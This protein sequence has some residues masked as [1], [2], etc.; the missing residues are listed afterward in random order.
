[1]TDAPLRETPLAAAHAA[2]GARFT[3]F[4]GWRMPLQYGSVLEEHRAVRASAGLFDLSHMG[5]LWVT[6]PGAGDALAY[7]LLTDPRR[8]AD[9][10]AQYTL[11]LN[12]AGGVLDDLIVYRLDA[13]R[14]LVVANAANADRVAAEL[15]ARAVGHD[16]LVDDAGGRTALIAVQGPRAAAIVAA[17]CVPDPAALRYYAITA[18][19]VA[20]HAAWV[21][22]TG[23]TG[24]DGFE[25]AVDWDAAP[26]VWDAL[27]AAGRPHGLVPCGLAARDTLRLEAAMPLYG[28]ELDA[29]TTPFEAGLGRLVKRDKP[30]DYVGR[31]ALEAPGADAPAR[32]LVGLRLAGRGIARPGYAVCRRGGE[33]CGLVTSGTM[34]PTLNQAIGLA[35]VPAEVSAPG[36]RLEVRIRDQAV[37]ADVVSTPFHRRPA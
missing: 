37:A 17:A 21:M 23:Y 32:R 12:D 11:L 35:Y 16:A 36:S 1:M 22:R 2:L 15:A 27:L 10:R 24:E 5:E 8:L 13:E 29:T 33:A 18:G 20:G 28:Q 25:I 31:A 30:G 9:G 3:P 4:A 26:A 34:S 6:G 14:W 19:Q 7:A